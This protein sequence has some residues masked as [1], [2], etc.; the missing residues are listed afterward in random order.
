[1]P[2][3]SRLGEPPL[4]REELDAHLVRL[5]A[6]G[7]AFDAVEAAYTSPLR[8]RAALGFRLRALQERAEGNGRAATPVA[9][10]A[11]EEVRAALEAVP[12]SVPLARHLVEQYDVVTRDLPPHDPVHHRKATP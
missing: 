11:A 2:D 1:M 7:R 10:A 5:T 3:V 6:V 4:G 8:E 9:V 12:C